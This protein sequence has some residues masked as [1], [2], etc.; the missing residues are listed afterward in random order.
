MAAGKKK[1]TD[2]KYVRQIRDRLLREYV[3]RHPRA[4]VSVK[5]YNSVSVRVRI[6]DPDFEGMSRAERDDAVWEVLD[7]LPEE[8]REE[9]SLL[10]LLTPEESKTSLMNVEFENP[11]PSPF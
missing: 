5:R 10:I 3:S 9:I 2:D 7:T 8:T 1:K 11:A 4:Q 6:I